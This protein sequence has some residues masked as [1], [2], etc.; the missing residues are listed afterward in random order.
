MELF[1][2]LLWLAISALVV[3]IWLLRT[4]RGVDP[5][6]HSIGVQLVAL[7]LLIVILLPVVSLTDDLH[8][9]Q[10]LAETDHVWRRGD[11]Q[12]AG[13]VALHLVSV[14][15]A[16]VTLLDISPRSRTLAWLS[17]PANKAA[18]CA[19]Y[20]RILGTRPPPAV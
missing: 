6:R 5:V 10:L 8:A 9:S 20:L 3:G 4:A 15:I 12:A 13:D 19:G 16:A 11:L 17:F 7:A 14:A 1:F 2:N 18:S